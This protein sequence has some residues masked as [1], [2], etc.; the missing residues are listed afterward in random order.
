[1]SNMTEFDKNSSIQNCRYSNGEFENQG[2][3]KNTVGLFY[4][5]SLLSATFVSL[6]SMYYK[7]KGYMCIIYSS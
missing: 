6:A 5:L 7:V 3:L 1:M 2:K 4:V